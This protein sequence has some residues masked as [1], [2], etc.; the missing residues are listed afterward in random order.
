MYG[1]LVNN[2]LVQAPAGMLQYDFE[3]NHIC[4]V[5]PS[6]ENYMQAGY[7]IVEYESISE[8]VEGT[9]TSVVYEELEEKIIVSYKEVE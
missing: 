1:K 6:E 9:E 5:N 3:G 2:E 8:M 4:A 7:K